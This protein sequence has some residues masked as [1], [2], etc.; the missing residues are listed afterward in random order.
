MKRQH[1][2]TPSFDF[3]SLE[4]VDVDQVVALGGEVIG[5]RRVWHEVPQSRFLSW[6][7]AMQRAY[8]AAR[9][10]DAADDPE[11][12]SMRTFYLERAAHYERTI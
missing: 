3:D 11:N 9:D 6:S 7:D 4:D 2:D 5:T 12:A 8:C 1:D 10:R